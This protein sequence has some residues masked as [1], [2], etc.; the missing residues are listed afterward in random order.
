MG[1]VGRLDQ[2]ASMLAWEFDDYSMSENLLTYSQNVSLWTSSGINTVNTSATTSPTG[3][4]NGNQIT[5]NSNSNNFNFAYQRYTTSTKGAYTFSLFVK[6]NDISTIS[7]IVGTDAFAA[8][9]ARATYTFSTQSF[10]SYQ[11]VGTPTGYV[12][13]STSTSYS[14]GWYKLSITFDTTSF[15]SQTSLSVGIYSG[16]YGSTAASYTKSFYVW[17]AQL[18][19]GSVAT[20]Y[21]P[22]TTTAINRVLAS[23]T[24]TNI[25]GLGTYYSSG[26]DE[27]VGF[28]TFLP[29]NVFMRQYTDKSVIV[30]NEIDE[31]TDFR[32][33]VTSGLVLDLDAGMNSSFNNTGT[34]W[35]DLSGNGNN[36][37]LTNGPTYSSANGGSIVFDGTNDYV[38]VN[39]NASILSSTAYTKI[40]WFYPTSFATGN[41]II[42]GTSANSQHAFWLQGSNRLYSGHNGSWST[43]LSTT[44]LFLNTWYYGAV[45]FNTTTGWNLYLNGALENTNASTTTFSGDGRIQIGAFDPGSNV[46][47]GRI[48]QASVY[49]RAL[50][51]AEVL[52][53]YNA[54]KHR[55]GL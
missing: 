52:Q 5:N 32:D 6:D 39:N 49:N 25:T 43:V 30:Y 54:L 34:T 23:T 36:G 53:N 12:S 13:S 37:T 22:T 11:Y 24:N 26:F 41:N 14:N 46:F 16:V 10:S 28:T 48:A 8:N 15:A 33:I 17:G 27:N 40:A 42:S 3:E 35:T 45:T 9:Y 21:T 44:T 31:I 51:A 4:I 2:Y 19:T 29:A 20:D 55:Y 50:T 38:V 47:T 1:V 18:E 7:I